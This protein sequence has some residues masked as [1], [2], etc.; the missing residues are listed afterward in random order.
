MSTHFAACSSRKW[1]SPQRCR[2]FFLEVGR[3]SRVLCFEREAG[4]RETVGAHGGH[5]LEGRWRDA[6]PKALRW[7]I[8]HAPGRIVRGARRV[9]VR[10]IDGWPTARQLLGA[11]QRRVLLT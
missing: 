4:S 5:C 3:R 2:E 7:E 1:P 8:F 6:R 10:V 11:Y 9:V